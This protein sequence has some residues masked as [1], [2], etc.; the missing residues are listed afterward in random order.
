MDILAIEPEGYLLLFFRSEHLESLRP[1]CH[2]IS[3][4]SSPAQKT[5]P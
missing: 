2:Y 5:Q 1:P 4:M 3:M